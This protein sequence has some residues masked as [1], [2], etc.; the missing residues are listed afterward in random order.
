MLHPGNIDVSERIHCSPQ[1][2]A[3]TRPA[4][5]RSVSSRPTAGECYGL[6]GAR[7]SRFR[8]VLWSGASRSLE[9]DRGA[10]RAAVAGAGSHGGDGAH[11]EQVGLHE[12]AAR[13]AAEL[14]GEGPG[15]AAGHVA[16]L[17]RDRRASAQEAKADVAALFA[18]RA[19]HA[20]ADGAVG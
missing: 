8:V 11:A 7:S 6:A 16:R 10:S 15:R 18:A 13:A 1:S 19:E 12:R 14:E 9:Q 5:A 20:E 2:A 4:L 3:S 17:G